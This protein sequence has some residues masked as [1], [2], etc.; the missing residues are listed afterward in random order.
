MYEKVFTHKSWAELESL[1]ATTGSVTPL[2]FIHRCFSKVPGG[3]S[4]PLVNFKAFS[5]VPLPYGNERYM[6]THSKA[7]LVVEAP[8]KS[9]QVSDPGHREDIEDENCDLNNGRMS[10]L[11]PTEYD[12]P[13]DSDSETVVE[14]EPNYSDLIEVPA[15]KSPVSGPVDVKET[16]R[17]QNDLIQELPP[18]NF[19][20]SDNFHYD[21]MKLVDLLE[22]Q[23]EA[24]LRSMGMKAVYVSSQGHATEKFPVDEASSP[25]EESYEPAMTRKMN[26]DGY[27]KVSS[28]WKGQEKQSVEPHPLTEVAI[29]PWKAHQLLMLGAGDS[30][31]KLISLESIHPQPKPAPIALKV[32]ATKEKSMT[33]LIPFD[34]MESNPSYATQQK[35]ALLQLKA[36]S[37]LQNQRHRYHY[38]LELTAKNLIHS[39]IG[40]SRVVDESANLAFLSSGNEM[41]ADDEKSVSDVAG[42]SYEKAV[43]TTLHNYLSVEEI[44]DI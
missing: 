9:H 1:N 6:E 15:I 11:P 24:M 17:M 5:H 22:V 43:I 21:N 36:P 41:D 38:D 31:P 8:L 4:V 18:Q 34:Q 2:E 30:R 25:H 37:V 44:G 26:F 39:R 12:S 35:V 23:R 16:A 14:T 7:K 13:I 42:K 19:Q 33:R 32:A 20:R 10:T 29:E 27:L 3:D 40:G 28:G